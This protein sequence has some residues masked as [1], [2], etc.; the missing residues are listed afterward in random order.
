MYSQEMSSFECSAPILSH[1]KQFRYF[2]IWSKDASLVP[3]IHCLAVTETPLITVFMTEF[4]T[5]QVFI[6]IYIY[7]F[8]LEDADSENTEKL[9]CLSANDCLADLSTIQA[10][11]VDLVGKLKID[12]PK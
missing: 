12:L 1:C 2:Q 11:T 9:S 6:Y 3:P 8:T 7:V 5:I 4:G 10:A